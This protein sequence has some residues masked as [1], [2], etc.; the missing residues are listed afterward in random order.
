MGFLRQI[1]TFLKRPFVFRFSRRIISGIM[2]VKLRVGLRIVFIG[3]DA[4]EYPR[5]FPFP[6]PEDR[7]ESMGIP[8]IEYLAR[9]GRADRRNTVCGFNGAFHQINAAVLLHD[10]AGTLRYAEHIFQNFH[11]VFALILDIVDGK[12]RFDG[13]IPLLSGIKQSL[14]YGNERG[15]PIIGVY[16]I[17]LKIDVFDHFEHGAG[18]E[19]EPLR[20]VVMTVKTCSLEIVLII[21]QIVD[22]AVVLGFKHTAVLTAPCHRNGEAGQEGHPLS[23]L[24]RD[25][26][27]QR[28]HYTA[29][30]QTDPQGFGQGTGYIR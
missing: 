8:G 6:Q 22:H 18:K 27:I 13:L 11:A 7:I 16:D 26:F 15:L 14:V 12:D 10:G 24:L 28:Q 19:S 21:E 2:A 9:V 20:I 29:A 23:Q 5:Q 25:R 17:G 4:V 1:Q 3:V 30:D